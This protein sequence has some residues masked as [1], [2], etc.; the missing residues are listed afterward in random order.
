MAMRLL[1]RGLLRRCRSSFGHR[2]L[3]QEAYRAAWP[4]L[5]SAAALYRLTAAHNTRFVA[6][7][8]SLGKTTTARAVHA[9]LHASDHYRVGPSQW[10][11]LAYRMLCTPPGRRHKVLEVGVDGFGQMRRFAALLRPDVAVVTSIASE[12]N[13]S[14]RTLAVTRSE[15][16]A[17]VAALPSDGVAVLNGD[18]PNVMWMA[19]RTRARV[20]TCGFGTEN[21]VRAED[22]RLCW[23]RG[24][25]FGLRAAGESR[26]VQIRLVGAPMVRCILAAVATALAEGISLDECL[27]RLEQLEPTVGRMQPVS[28]PG[29]AF[30]LRD[31]YKSTL[32]AMDAAL[33][34]LAQVEAPRRIVVFGDVAEAPGSA[35]PMYRR[36]GSRIAGIAS[37]AIFVGGSAR[38]YA[39]GARRAGMDG[40]RI[41]RVSRGLREAVDT[42]RS[43]LRKG[44]VVLIKGRREQRLERITL[45]LT[46]RTVDCGLILCPTHGPQCD[47]CPMLGGESPENPRG[48]QP[49]RA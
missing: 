49:R 26:C 29:G 2:A 33:D 28:L 36:L 16:S 27:P 39:T 48:H 20:V 11:G 6:V 24:T 32:E 30:V 10:S 43:E 41:V 21:T 1:P 42:L 15:K 44:D 35:G 19:G 47:D 3:R 14:F 34:A 8:G 31:D 18:D 23:P 38:R 4:L 17:M 13:R 25:S 45:S 37:L 7:I 5:G 46:G 22:V 40:S 12:H 9:A